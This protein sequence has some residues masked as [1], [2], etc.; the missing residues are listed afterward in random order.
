[1]PGAR[2]WG[3]QPSSSLPFVAQNKYRARSNCYPVTAGSLCGIARQSRRRRIHEQARHG[4]PQRR[5]RQRQSA[6]IEYR[7]G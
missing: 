4:I 1:M 7:Q 6:A 2:P 3:S 5:D